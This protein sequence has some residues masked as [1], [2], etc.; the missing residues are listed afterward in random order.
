ME[1]PS[2]KISIYD[3]AKKLSISASTVSR[4]L[5]DSK[6]VKLERRLEIQKIAVQMGYEPNQAA[7]NLKS[8]K[9]NAIAILVP[10]INRNFFSAII[11]G[12]A[13]EIYKANYDLLICYSM[14]QYNREVQIV[15]NLSRGKVDGLLACVAAETTDMLH[16]EKIINKGVTTVF[17]DRKIN[18]L[19]AAN[20]TIDDFKAAYDATE[21]LLNQ[22]CRRIFHFAGPQTRSNWVER[23]RGYLAALEKW[24][25]TPDENWIYIAP[26]LEQEGELFAQKI[27][28]MV[29]KPDA[30][31]FTG[32]Y[33]AKACIR[34]FNE[35]QIRIPQDIA[36]VGFGNDP[37]DTMLAPA[38]SSVDQHSY[39]IGSMAAKTLLE[40][41]AGQPVSS[42][43]IAPELIARES[44]LLK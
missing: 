6:S 33:P 40:I 20:V 4:A 38:L 28:E 19:G 41:I 14:E 15:N 17:F 44:S 8:G 7:V 21:H 29:D 39:K 1:K 2:K 42:V 34:V 32:D 26:T 37:F 36:I 22:G 18:L 43:V 3:I 5:G 24:G 10:I 31:F 27:V 16:F 12:A 35:K 9:V 30:I 11:E 13:S 25:V 23:R